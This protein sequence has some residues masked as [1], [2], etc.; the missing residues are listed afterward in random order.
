MLVTSWA[1]VCRI[2]LVKIQ[3]HTKASIHANKCHFEWRWSWSISCQV[4]ISAF[5][6]AEQ[7]TLHYLFWSVL[8][9]EIYNFQHISE[10]FDPQNGSKRG[11]GW[12]LF[13][14][15]SLYMMELLSLVCW[16]YSFRE[17]LLA[18]HDVSHHT[19]TASL[20]YKGLMKGRAVNL[21]WTAKPKNFPIH[22]GKTGNYEAAVTRCTHI[23]T[24]SHPYTHTKSPDARPWSIW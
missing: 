24:P 15:G 2:L 6:S 11:D 23:H 22:S 14:G 9:F 13:F 17:T 19:T 7:I 16:I 3:V 21:I 12:S 5:L 1:L 4:S 8:C 18:G 10:V 20:L